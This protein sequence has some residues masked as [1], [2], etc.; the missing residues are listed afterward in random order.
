MGPPVA[1]WIHGH[2]HESCDYVE[3]GT[4]VLCNP[5]GYGPFELNATFDPMLTH[6]DRPLE[7]FAAGAGMDRAPATTG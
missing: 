3:Q 6:R 2:T 5:R 7:S 4:R 1:V